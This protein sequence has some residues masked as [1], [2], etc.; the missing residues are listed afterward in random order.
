MKNR[1]PALCFIILI[2]LSLSSI[3][4]SQKKEQLFKSVD[5]IKRKAEMS[6]AAILSPINFEKA[7]KFYKEAEQL[8]GRG[9]TAGSVDANLNA[10]IDYYQRAHNFAIAGKQKLNVGFDAR[11]AAISTGAATH[12]GSIWNDAEQ[13]FAD[14][15]EELELGHIEDAVNLS[16]S[17]A[18]LYR[19]AELISIK[20]FYLGEA[21][22]LIEQAEELEAEEYAPKT[23]KKAK[24]LAAFAEKELSLNRY[25]TQRPKE[26]AIEALYEAKHTIFFTNLFKKVKN[27]NIT[28]EELLLEV[29]EPYKAIAAAFGTKAEID[30]G[31]EHVKL[32]LLNDI[33]SLK[34]LNND[35]Q[36]EN[37]TLVRKINMIESEEG[38]ES[39]D[40]TKVNTR[41][42]FEDEVRNKYAEVRDLFK[43]SEASISKEGNVIKLRLVGLLFDPGSSELKEYHFTLLKKVVD[44]VKKFPEAKVRIEGHTDSSG[45]SIANMR[46]SEER[47]YSVFSYIKSNAKIDLAKYSAVGYGQTN[48]IASNGTRA[49]RAM[50]SRV[51]VVIMP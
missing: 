49:G 23:L 31:Y 30:K 13:K 36:K 12:A 7:T 24:S 42:E 47:A 29:E 35:L 6:D 33:D 46:L 39:V 21:N 3:L 14:A 18:K 48:P 34:K 15:A 38:I 11:K 10:A 20:S 40:K 8:V 27:D 2:M 1:I 26:L 19:Q 22:K 32:Q 5:D 17:A 44:A 45:D 37:S 41:W 25:D 51:D 9:V 4:Y 16:E 50:N 28:Y 43:Q